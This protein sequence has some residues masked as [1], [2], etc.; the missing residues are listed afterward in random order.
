MQVGQRPSCR[1]PGPITLTRRMQHFDADDD[2]FPFNARMVVLKSSD[3]SDW[4]HQR[5][6][7]E[8]FGPRCPF[9]LHQAETSHQVRGLAECGKTEA[10]KE[11]QEGKC[12]AED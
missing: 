11:M 5:S 6:L 8:E 1:P 4:A 2:A 3:P 12:Y 9:G 10:D 7:I